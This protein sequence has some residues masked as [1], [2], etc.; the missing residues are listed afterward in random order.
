MGTAAWFCDPRA[1]WQKGTV[2]NT[3][4]RVRGYLPR[5]TVVLDVSNQEVRSLCERLNATPALI[6]YG[7]PDHIDFQP[8]LHSVWNQQWFALASVI[9]PAHDL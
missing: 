3:N 8:A 5:E 9:L 7:G 1:P 2:E 4:K 6:G